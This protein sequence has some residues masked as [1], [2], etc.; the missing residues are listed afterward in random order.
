VN[1]PEPL[2]GAIEVALNRYLGLDAAA[3]TDLAALHGRCL[4]ITIEPPGWSFNFEFIGRGVRVSGL[5]E[6]TPDVRVTGA[7]GLFA[8]LASEQIRG[9][10]Q[11]PRGLRVEGDPE[12]LL[13]FQSVLSRIGFDL[14]EMLEPWLGDIAA[15][16]VADAARAFFSWG[17]KTLD[18]LTL[19]TAEYL[20]EETGD[21]VHA[22]DANAFMDEVDSLRD[23]AERLAA[24]VARLERRQGDKR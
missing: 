23:G 6:Q 4:A 22:E 16:R 7:P 3:G 20:R 21:L 9:A 2:C 5:A 24:R 8:R 11:L 17:R 12:L 10:S 1:A 19:D 13:R 18:T 14:A 15:Q